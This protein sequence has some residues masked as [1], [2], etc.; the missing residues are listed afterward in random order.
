MQKGIYQ[1]HKMHRYMEVGVATQGGVHAVLRWMRCS[2]VC[3]G[4]VMSHVDRTGR[5]WT[6]ISDLK[7][8]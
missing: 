7:N 1:S 8:F 3:F 2:L 6:S 5:R 4:D